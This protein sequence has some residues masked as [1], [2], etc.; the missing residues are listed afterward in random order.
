MIEHVLGHAAEDD[1]PQAAVRIGAD[2]QEVGR[3]RRGFGE[4]DVPDPALPLLDV[5]RL[6]ADPVPGERARGERGWAR[7][8]ARCRPT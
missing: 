1:L 4:E 2:D 3:H 8:R 6:C 5:L 7:A